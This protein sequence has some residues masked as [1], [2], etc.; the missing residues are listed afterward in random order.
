MT[1]KT[2]IQKSKILLVLS[3]ALL[4]QSCYTYKTIDINAVVVNGKTHKIIQDY[5]QRKVK[6]ITIKDSSLVIQ[7]WEG[8]REVQ[9]SAIDKIKIKKFSPA[10]TVGIT[11]IS[12]LV[13]VATAIIVAFS[14]IKYR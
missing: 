13:V 6:I 8:Q 1:F 7:D 9:K 3:L 14:N 4:F 10:L 11:V 12:V 5:E 2:I